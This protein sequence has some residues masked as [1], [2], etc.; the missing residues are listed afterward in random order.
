MPNYTKEDNFDIQKMYEKAALKY[1]KL[2]TNTGVAVYDDGS[3]IVREEVGCHGYMSELIGVGTPNYWGAYGQEP[4]KKLV[5]LYTSLWSRNYDDGDLEYFR[6][7]CNEKYS[8]WRNH[9][10]GREVLFGEKDGKQIPIAVKLTDMTASTQVVMNFF[11]ASRMPWAQPGLIECYKKLRKEGFTRTESV[12]LSANFGLNPKQVP[13]WPYFGD[14]PYDTSFTNMS[15]KRFSEGNPRFRKNTTLNESADYSPCNNAWNAANK[16]SGI[17]IFNGGTKKNTIIQDL[18]S[19]KKTVK[20]VFGKEEVRQLPLA[21]DAAVAK[22]KDN[23][24][25]WKCQTKE[26]EST[27]QAE[28]QIEATQANSIDSSPGMGIPLSV[29]TTVNTMPWLFTVP[30]SVSLQSYSASYL[31]ANSPVSTSSTTVSTQGW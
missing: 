6:Y 20:T 5:A 24:E 17:V 12:F 31:S 29:P 14:F 1:P 23:K 15:W 4:T 13:T 8:P 22:L 28:E 30:G 18:I 26:E 9:I 21:W 16:P 27:S 11:L 7:I 3:I 25:A 2:G 19:E 10:K